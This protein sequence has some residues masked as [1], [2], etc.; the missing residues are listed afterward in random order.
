MFS[1]KSSDSNEHAPDLNTKPPIATKENVLPKLLMGDEEE[2]ASTAVNDYGPHKRKKGVSTSN[3][4]LPVVSKNYIIGKKG[5]PEEIEHTN[6]GKIEMKEI[7]GHLRKNKQDKMFFKKIT[8]AATAVGALV[9]LCNFGLVW[10][11]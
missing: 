2:A 3:K 8:Y 4:T 11:T 7:V 6:D 9:V 1:A 5:Y 10:A